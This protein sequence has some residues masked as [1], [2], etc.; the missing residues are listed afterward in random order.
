MSPK[1]TDKIDW[2]KEKKES[3]AQIRSKQWNKQEIALMAKVIE[4]GITPKHVFGRDWFPGR[5]MTSIRSQI[6]RQKQE[7][8]QE[9]IR[10]RDRGAKRG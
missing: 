4:H 5:S 9:E 10:K 8:T 3:D 1:K 7:I 2:G 6:T